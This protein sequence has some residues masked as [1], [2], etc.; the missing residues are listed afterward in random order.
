MA[1]VAPASKSSRRSRP[2]APAAPIGQD[3][4]SLEARRLRAAPMFERGSSPAEV[5]R[6]LGVARQS[7]SRWHRAWAEGGSAALASSG[8]R[9]RSARLSSSELKDVE[10]AL[11]KG[12]RS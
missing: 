7:A 6:V 9:G 8:K 1:Q 12:A 5:A 3:L 4:A 10:S 2:E 11:R